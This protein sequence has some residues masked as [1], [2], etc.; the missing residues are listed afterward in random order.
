MLM[1]Q[2]SAVASESGK[3]QDDLAEQFEVC[4]VVVNSSNIFDAQAT[5]KAQPGLQSVIMGINRF[6]KTTRESVILREIGITERQTLSVAEVEDIERRLRRLGIFASVSATLYSNDG[7]TELRIASRDNF[8]IVA[9]ASGSYLGGIGNVGFT[10]GDKNVLGTGNKLLLGLSR[11]SSGDFRGS[12]TF[13]DLHFFDSDW[14]ANYRLGRTNEGDFYSVNLGDTFRSLNDNRA[15]LVSVDQVEN[16]IKY[17][18]DGDTVV[19]IPQNRFTLSGNHVWRSGSIN[20]YVRRGLVSS[21]TN[22]EYSPSIGSLANTVDVPAD[23]SKYYL[24]SVVGVDNVNQFM[25]VQGLD[26][27]N[28]VQDLSLGSTSELQFGLNFIDENISGGEMRVEPS[29]SLLLRKSALLGKHTLLSASVAGGAT[30]EEGGARPWSSSTGVKAFYTKFDKNTLAMRLDYVVG[31]DGS[32]LPVQYTLGENN[33]LRGYDA[34]QFEGKQRVRLN[35]ESRYRPGWSLGVLDVGMV[36][37]VDGGWTLNK[38]EASQS[39]KHSIGAGLRLAS[40]AIL[41]ARVIRVDF[42]VPLDAPAG[43]SSDPRVSIAVGQTFR[44]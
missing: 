1:L 19:S 11:S 35:L 25:K 44:F 21:F 7:C 15:W 38:D 20:R 14:R 3:P 42:A 37:F 17:F 32:G 8:S 27:I 24:G 30:F 28:F 18:Q 22:V 41:G 29:V 4:R 34:R 6:H 10:T 12:I 16:N 5:N 39:V 2:V 40:N 13:N 26:T 23:N 33:G 9:G 43:D 36:G 31:E